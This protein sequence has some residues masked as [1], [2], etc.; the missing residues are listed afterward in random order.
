M[1]NTVRIPRLLSLCVILLF[2]AVSSACAVD[3]SRP[4]SGYI[5]THFSEAD[6]LST[7]VVSQIVQSRDGFLW[8]HVAS[9]L[10]R[11]DGRDFRAFHQFGI[12]TTI[13]VAE[14]GDLW[15]GTADGLKQIPAATL[16]QSIIVPATS[17]QPGPGQSSHITSLHFTRSGILWVG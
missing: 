15:V 10:L 2:V 3:P 17:Y 8:L 12:V 7:N 6:G 9:Y 5:R 1:T 13:A 11:F 16:S 4:M 14:D